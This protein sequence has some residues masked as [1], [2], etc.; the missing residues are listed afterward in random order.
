MKGPISINIKYRKVEYEFSLK[1]KFTVLTGESGSC[2]SALIATI[3]SLRRM[4]LDKNI[5]C[6]YP[7]EFITDFREIQRFIN[8]SKPKSDEEY[9][10]FFKNAGYKDTVFIIDEDCNGIH[11]KNFA[12][13]AQSVNCFF[14]FITRDPLPMLP[15][16]MNEIYTLSC[17]KG[18]YTFQQMYDQ[19]LD[20]NVF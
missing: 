11:T 15:Y 1:R 14:L 10:E 2:K 3:L 20:M 18:K 5:K 12:K 7:I 4:G 17:Y 13:F 9:H 19:G 8:A 6:D 16:S